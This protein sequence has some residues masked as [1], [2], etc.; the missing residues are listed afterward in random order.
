MVLRNIIFVLALAASELYAQVDVLTAQYNL[1]RTSSNT[2]EQILNRT[3]VNSSQ[4]GKLFSRALDAPF[5]ASPLIVTNF[6]V[7]GVG[8][9]N[10]VYIATLGN[11][12]YAFDADDPHATSA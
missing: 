2:Q 8:Q 6:N 9:R 10:L 7:P 1:S 5:Y 11:T 12:V 4:F 3:N